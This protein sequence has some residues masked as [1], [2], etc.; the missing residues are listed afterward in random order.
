MTIK[1]SLDLNCILC[2]FIKKIVEKLHQRICK[3]INVKN[4]NNIEIIINKNYIIIFHSNN[5]TILEIFILLKINKV[6][7]K[8]DC[9]CFQWEKFDYWENKEC[10]YDLKIITSRSIK[11]NEKFLSVLHEYNRKKTNYQ[12]LNFIKLRYIFTKLFNNK[13]N[14][15]RLYLLFEVKL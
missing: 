14:L 3:N 6:I 10:K 4:L 1:L 8:I 2:F 5:I 15:L 13:L 11:I 9:Q 7:N 12:T